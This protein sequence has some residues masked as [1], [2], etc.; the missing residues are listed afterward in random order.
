MTR[1]TDAEIARWQALARNWL[2]PVTTVDDF[3]AAMVAPLILDAL[4]AERE[5]HAQTKAHMENNLDLA[6]RG[7]SAAEEQLSRALA[8]LA[9]ARAEGVRDA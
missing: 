9:T 7:R 8:D 2:P 3:E 5:A 1:A 6:R 4:I